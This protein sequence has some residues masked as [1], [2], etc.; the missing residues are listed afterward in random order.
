[1][2]FRHHQPEQ[3][4]G[5][6]AAHPPGQA[7][8][9]VLPP[10]NRCPAPPGQQ[11]HGRRAGTQGENSVHGDHVGQ[12]QLHP[13]MGWA[14]GV[15]ASTIKMVRAMAVSRASRVTRRAPLTGRCV[16]L[17][18]SPRDLDDDLIGQA[19]DGLAAVADPPWWTHTWS[20]QEPRGCRY[21]PAPPARY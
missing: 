14:R 21:A 19:D 11:D 10:A 16:N 4:H 12:P 9:M 2:L 6:E 5:Q 3:G 20:G 7:V 8:K 13:G 1:M 18:P 17:A 15:W